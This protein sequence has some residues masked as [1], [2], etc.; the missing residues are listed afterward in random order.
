MLSCSLAEL[1]SKREP[2]DLPE[3]CSVG[4]EGHWVDFDLGS[5]LFLED[6][7]K[8]NED[9]GSLVLSLLIAEAEFLR[10]L[11]SLWLGQAVLELDGGG[12]DSTG[13]LGSDLLDVV[14]SL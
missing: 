2:N 5:V 7:V 10:D 1:I 13:V 3:H 11:D 12:D 8:V 14:A 9:V 4:S 6:T